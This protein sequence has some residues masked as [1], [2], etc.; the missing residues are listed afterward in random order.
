MPDAPLDPE[1]FLREQVAPRVARRV[2]ELRQQVVRLEAEIADRLAAEAVV[3]LVLDGD[4]GG[5]W[6]LR[7]A[8]GQM[9]VATET[10]SPP[11]VRVFQ[12]RG[13]WEALA[14]AQAA[15]GGTGAPVGADLT[16]TR[17]DRLR[18]LQG[19]LEFRL[20]EDDGERAVHVHFGA[21][22]RAAPR[23]TLRMRAEDARR[24][25]A[26]DLPPQV[27]FLS[28]LVKIEGDVAFAMQVGA[29]LVL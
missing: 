2:E 21:G 8:G 12:S 1:T 18:G 27:A 6:F 13:D 15:G 11:L 5:R 10:G 24:L 25:Q 9:E 22:E 19:G 23:C 20:L 16:R 28:G 7:L 26:G 3:E 17:I 29:A 14:R 4:G